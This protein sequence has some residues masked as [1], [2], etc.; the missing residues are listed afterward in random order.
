MP[1]W[2]TLALVLLLAGGLLIVGTAA[3]MAHLLLRPP[4]M[5]DGKA[6]W[7]L[8]RLSP[9][10][11]GLP[12]EPMTFTVRDGR[13]AGRRTLD[14]AAW[15][16]PHAAAGGKCA[17]L[18]HGYADAKVGA[19][20]WAPTFAALGYHML[21]ID[22]RA[23]GESGGKLM[24]AGYHERDDL[25]QV[26]DQLRAAKPEQTRRLVLFGASLG[27]VVCAAAAEGRDDVAAVV[28]DSPFADYAHASEEHLAFLGLPVALH[29]LTMAFAQRD[30]RA[31]FDAV[32]PPDVIARLT[33]DAL[34][35]LGAADPF[36]DEAG[37]KAFADA[38]A[39]RPGRRELWVVEGAGHLMALPADPAEYQRR[40]EAF[41]SAPT[42]DK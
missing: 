7:V 27:A 26:L 17:V 39:A 16:L 34:V 38:L 13:E 19:L 42:N 1:V 10:D 24:S 36:V 15:W 9:G 14:L 12:Y 30:A 35:I 22:L 37:R 25:R 32:R 29:G 18:V 41:L 31:R 5:N 11:L 21:L 23:H 33:C 20:A 8:K 3:L 28:L 4:R 2:L 6:A 40:V